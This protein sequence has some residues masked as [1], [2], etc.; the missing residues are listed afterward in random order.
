M[1]GTKIEWT[2]AICLHCGHYP[3]HHDRGDAKQ[4]RGYNPDAEN[5]MCVCPGWEPKPPRPEPPAEQQPWGH[6]R[7]DLQ[8]TDD[9]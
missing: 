3:A 9:A 4:C 1:D 8:D 6:E 7:A 2:D 5:F